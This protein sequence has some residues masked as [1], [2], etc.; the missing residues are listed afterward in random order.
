MPTRLIAASAPCDARRRPTA[1]SVTSARTN[2]TWPS[3]PERLQE[4]GAPRVALGDADAHAG[5][6]QRLGDVA[7]EKAAAAEQGDEQ[8]RLGRHGR[9]FAPGGAALTSPEAARKARAHDVSGNGNGG[10]AARC[11]IRRR[12]GRGCARCTPR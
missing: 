10:G 8:I 3:P 5:L 9:A 12:T 1:L 4:P 2:W 11:A 6:Q 7:A